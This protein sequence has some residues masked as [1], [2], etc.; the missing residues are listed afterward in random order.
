M[1]RPGAPYLG[2]KMS[3]C[4]TLEYRTCLLSEIL[5]YML[6]IIKFVVSAKKKHRVTRKPLPENLLTGQG[7][8]P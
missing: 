2:E 6:Y 8:L 1:G 3:K 5:N 7:S 4:E